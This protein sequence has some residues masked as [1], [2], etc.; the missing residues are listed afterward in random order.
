MPSSEYGGSEMKENRGFQKSLACLAQPT[1]LLCIGILLLNDHVLKAVAPSWLTGKISD[2]AGLFFFPFIVVAGLSL[3][4]GKLKL[5]AKQ[6]GFL[7]F[8]IVAAWF[9]ALKTLPLANTIT[10]QFAGALL[11]RPSSF[12]LDPTDLMALVG[13]VPAWILWNRQQAVSPKRLG[14]L[15]L[16]AG[17]VAAMATS[18]AQMPTSV[19]AL[20]V[21]GD[22]VYAQTDGYGMFRSSDAGA[23]WESCYQKDCPTI[24][25]LAKPRQMPITVCDASSPEL[26]FRISG[27]PAIDASTDGGKTWSAAWEIPEG[28]IP[29]LGRSAGSARLEEITPQDLIIVQEPRSYLLVA[30]G[31]AGVLRKALPNGQW[32]MI[33]VGYSVPIRYTAP[34][35]SYGMMDTILELGIWMLISIG[36]LAAAGLLLWMNGSLDM[37]IF[38]LVGWVLLTLGSATAVVF[39]TVFLIGQF[40]VWVLSGMSLPGWLNSS[41]FVF[42]VA[43]I[44]VYAALFTSFHWSVRNLLRKSKQDGQAQKTFRRILFFMAAANCIAALIIWPFWALGIIWD[45][46]V[47]LT[48]A[49][50]CTAA[51]AIVGLLLIRRED[52]RLEDH[53]ASL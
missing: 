43:A 10:A 50:V 44:L 46:D 9:I 12:A 5:D 40:L 35:F 23:T 29:Y 20:A 38:R 33:E 25:E 32:Q 30:M 31:K 6:L 18:P 22:K 52:A 13:L 53:P 41:D 21:S 17:A 48:S 3:L 27:K 45:Y 19:E 15:A 4:P 8:G 47:A 16:C 28:R 7:S 2:F 14:Y 24:P 34:Y 26:C 42:G 51:I 1:S 11:G 36:L 37:S 39:I 49:I